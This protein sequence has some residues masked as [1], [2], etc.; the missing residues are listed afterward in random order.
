MRVTNF[1]SFKDTG[2][3]EF[4]PGI[5]LI[6]GQNNAGKSALLHA[7]DPFLDDNR[8]RDSITYLPHRLEQPLAEYDIEVSGPEIEDSFL[9]GQGFW[10]PVKDKSNA[11]DEIEK[12]FEFMSGHN[13]IMEVAR[14]PQ[15]GFRS[16]RSP[17]HGQFEGAIGGSLLVNV[18]GGRLAPGI[19]ANPNDSIIDAVN[20]LWATNLFSFKAQRYSIG[21]CDLNTEPTRLLPNASNLPVILLQLQGERGDLFKLLVSQ[22]RE[23]FSTVENLSLVRSQQQNGAVEIRVWPT[24]EQR[25]LELSFDLD[26]CG[27]GVAQVIAILTIVMTFERAVIVIDEISS[28]L[29]PAAVKTLLRII[30]TNYAQHQYIIAT[31]SPE[32]LSAR[33]PATVHV[34]RRHGYDSVVER[35]DLRELDQ[36]RDIADDLG[37]SMTDFFGAE[38]IIWVEGRT[39]EL[40]FPFIYEKTV[41]QLPRGLI[42]TPVINTGDFN[43][44]KTRRE[45]LFQIYQRV[46][47][48]ASPLIKSAAFGFDRE[49]LTDDEIGVLKEKSAGRVLFLPRRLFEC[50]LLDPVAIAELINNQVSD[51]AKP[52]S[53]DEVQTYLQSVGEDEKFK[54]AKQ[55][56]GDIFD[57]GWLAKVDAAALLRDAFHRLTETRLE[58]TKTRHSLELLKHILEHNP[59][60]LRTLID[61]VK[62]LFELAQRDVD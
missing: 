32:V 29:H 9:K 40:C 56:K 24:E 54:A 19:N 21:K 26:N 42:I 51:L 25:Q 60:S 12:F 3:I 17:S 36:L 27:T 62:E 59:A 61:Y 14:P 22:L 20:Q 49:T 52:I 1:S 13:H 23:V 33:N 53:P 41:G 7:F 43:A 58:F 30:Q 37:I 11:S 44:K 2:W 39:E 18:V 4:A 5:N 15:Q 38:R 34:V 50:Y 10:W 28:F 31:H 55:W 35:V 57:E 6:V 47:Q 8:H 16:R 46:H 48:V 45:L